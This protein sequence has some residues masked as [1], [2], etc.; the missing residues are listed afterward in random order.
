MFVKLECVTQMLQV[1]GELVCFLPAEQQAA[2][3]ASDALQVLVPLGQSSKR[4]RVWKTW[5]RWAL[6]CHAGTAPAT[7]AAHGSGKHSQWTSEH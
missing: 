6:V 1:A 2:D 5:K 3:D 7:R 4:V